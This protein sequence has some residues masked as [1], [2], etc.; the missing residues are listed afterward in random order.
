M[1]QR[2][3]GP[4]EVHEAQARLYPQVLPYDGL[5]IASD[6]VLGKLFLS[7]D[8]VSFETHIVQSYMLH[9]KWV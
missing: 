5:R 6:K 9:D 7:N 4:L 8:W 2:R 1:G 3:S